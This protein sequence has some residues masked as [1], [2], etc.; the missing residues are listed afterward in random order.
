MP[1]DDAVEQSA[2]PRASGAAFYVSAILSALF[3]LRLLGASWGSHFPAVWPDATFPKEGYLAVAAKSPFRPSFYNA[4]RPIGYPFFLWVFGR[5]TQLT[6]VAQAALYCAVVA[7]LIVTA[8]RALQERWV[9]IATAVLIGGIAI[10]AK[11]ALW[12]TQILSESLSISLGL[13]A[14]AAWWRFAA[15]PTRSRAVWGFAFLTAWLVV[16]DAHV[17]PGAVVAV[18]AVL[19][20]AWLGTSLGPQIR[21]TL[22]AGA[23]V[24]V[25]TATY[26]YFAQNAAHRTLSFHNVVGMRILPDAELRNWFVAR[27]MPLDDALRSRTGKSGMD[28]KFYANTDP[29]FAAYR[30]WA[31]GPGER[32][33]AI[34]LGV[35]APHYVSLMYDD[36]PSILAEDVQYYDTQGVYNRLPREMPLQLGGPSTR[37]GLTTWLVLGVLALAAGFAL[38]LVRR[39]GI[40]LVVFG[41]TALVFALVELYTTWASDPVEMPRHMVGLL[42]RMSIV[43][44]VV[45]GSA[46]DTGIDA[47]RSRAPREE[48]PPVAPPPWE[49]AFDAE[50]A[51]QVPPGA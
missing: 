7:A 22:V 19:L 49:G 24:L 31:R 26:A 40:G 20:V 9:A 6:V 38:A 28:D 23:V 50:Y 21:K 30:H 12:T 14:L 2:R 13:A 15:A 46:V 4:Y 41:T 17:L 35:K 5:N 34:S 18:P 25:I 48:P 33:F 1:D 36:L 47:W 16:R 10:Q 29:A 11:Y 45:I 27:G 44:V 32:A 8:L 37:R 43:L 39:R 51:S 3:L 42:S